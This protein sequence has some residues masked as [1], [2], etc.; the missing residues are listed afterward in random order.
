MTATA[1]L[2]ARPAD[3]QRELSGLTSEEPSR[4]RRLFATVL[5]PPAAARVL[6]R[7]LGEMLALSAAIAV[8][9]TL[10]GSWLAAMSSRETGP[11]IVIVAATIFLAA[12]MIGSRCRKLHAEGFSRSRT[13]NAD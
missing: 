5:I 7:N 2:L 11:T 4:R 10:G 8:G 1:E 12:S 13:D 3:H 6:A 9:S